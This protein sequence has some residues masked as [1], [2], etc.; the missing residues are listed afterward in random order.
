MMRAQLPSPPPVKEMARVQPSRFRD[1]QRCH[2]RALYE[3]NRVV[4]ALPRPALARLGSAIHKVLEEAGRGQLR[5]DARAIRE[6]LAE[7]VSEQEREMADGWLERHF[8]PL[9]A[10]VPGFDERCSAAVDRAYGIAEIAPGPRADR[11]A[12]GRHPDGPRSVGPEVWQSTEDGAVGGYIDLLAQGADGLEVTD[13]KS[14]HIHG[15]DGEILDSHRCQLAMYGSILEENG[16]GWPTA[17]VLVP[18]RG[19]PISVEATPE[20]GRQLLTS[21]RALRAR[22]NAVV[23]QSPTELAI[24]EELAAPSEDGCRW[25]NYRPLCRPYLRSLWR[26]GVDADRRNIA[27]ELESVD[28]LGNGTSLLRLRC[29]EAGHALR[30]RGLTQSPDRHPALGEM[31]PGDGV[32][33]FGCRERGPATFQEAPVTTLYRSPSDINADSRATG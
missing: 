12:R 2:L 8:A 28:T 18:L 30:V 10:S 21:A 4:G 13:F 19:A 11:A 17:M 6:R 16:R 9:H 7:L 15:S 29:G 5:A 23:R 22:V 31:K 26:V 25:C 33:V 27:G 20:E 24:Q 3:A 14:G 32:F 1:W